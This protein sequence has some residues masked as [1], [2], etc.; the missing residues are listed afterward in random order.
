MRSPFLSFVV[1]VAVLATS[2]ASAQSHTVAAASA[3]AIRSDASA[4]QA[5][6]VPPSDPQRIRL[7]PIGT[8]RSNT[9]A[10]GGAE[11]V[12]HDPA[13]QRL[14]IVNGSSKSIDIVSVANPAAPTL[15]RSIAIAPTYGAAATSVDI[16]NGVLAVAVPAADETA[17]GKVV[18][19]NRE[20]TLINQVTVGVLPDMLTFTPDGGYVL[21]ANE[22]QPTAD[23]SVDPEGSV[24][25]VDV[26]NGATNA[27]VRAVRFTAFNEGQPRN[28]ELGDDVRVFG[29]G[30]SVAE[31]LEP[32]YIA[33]SPDGATA[34]VSLQEN[35]AIA[36]IDLAT[37]TVSSISVLGFKDYGAAGNGIDASDRDGGINIQNWPVKGMYQPDAI[38][39]YA[40]GGET[41]V[42][43][44]NEGDA[45][46]YDGFSEQVRVGS[47]D[48][49]LDPSSFPNAA[50]LQG[51]AQLGRLR[52]TNTLGRNGDDDYEE[53]YAFGGRSFSILNDE[54]EVI[55][56]SG[57]DIEQRTAQLYP[58][59]FNSDNEENSSFDNRSD[60]KGPEPE[61][62]A[63]GR[64]GGRT[65]A[66]I[67][68]ER[69]GGVMVY[70][71]TTP[72]SPTFVQ[73]INNRDFAGD[74][75]AGTAGDLGPEGLIFVPADDSP[76]SQPLVVV[77]NEISGSTTLYAV[78][79]ADSDGAGTLSLLHNNDGESSLLPIPN[80]VETVTGTVQLDTAGVAAFKT[81]TDRNIAQAEAA[82]NAVVNVY[83]GDAFLASATLACSLPPQPATTPIYDAVA[84][85]QID[86]DAHIIGN[87]EFDYSPDFLER[88][89]RA[90]EEGGELEEPFLSANLD[91]SGE[92]GFADL[93]DPD[94]L[95]E[96][97]VEDNRPLARSMVLTDTTTSQRF[98][99]VGATTP[100]LPTISSPRNVE[101]TPTITETAEAVQTEIDRLY[102]DLGVRKIILVSHLQ[103]VNNDR[104]LIPRL[105][106]V[107]LAVAGGGDELLASTSVPTT[108]QLLPGEAAPIA[109]SYPLEVGDADGRTVYVVTTA[110]NYKYLGR[111][112]VEFDA[113]GEVSDIVEATS[114]PRRVIPESATAT[115]LGLT[116]AVPPDPG[117]VSTVIEP[118][119]ECLA[120]FANTVVATSEVNLDVSRNGV[121]STESNGGNLI[122]D[123]F[124]A[125]YERYAEVNDL[126]STDEAKVIAVQNGGGIR[127]NAGDSLP[128]GGAPGPIT[129]LD[130]LN[131][132]PFDNF[133]SVVRNVT[134]ADLK[135]I[136]E[137]SAES[138]PGQGGQF[139][140]VAGIKV[141]Y[142]VG[143][144]VGSRVVSLV[145]DDGTPI[146]QNGEVVAGAPVVNVVTNSF[147]ANGGDNYP[148]FASYTDKPRLF[149]DEGIAISYEQTLVEYLQELGVVRAS[150]V[151]YRPGGD[152]RILIFNVLLRLPLVFK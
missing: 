148:T 80:T 63:V 113:E 57:D 33:V 120:E 21:T 29:P 79:A 114:Y 7:Q 124:L 145:L 150:D 83:A 14:Y 31:D 4:L 66:F 151:R 81:V 24:S 76:N 42:V 28:G 60:D 100:T 2:L 55:F 64:L 9:F 15:I 8:Y 121:R 109:G 118:V 103:D 62:L 91:F 45:R 53:L 87:H 49:V 133:M 92:P 75:A 44:A 54:G 10:E 78:E 107:D 82:G 144:P 127:Q 147:T 13:T 138:L 12:T 25:I 98:G 136:F 36:I 125:A 105:S 129:R 117:I 152:D 27:S 102:D 94:G 86:Y 19:F 65:Y 104:E 85:R 112:D 142:K 67:G 47:D 72:I 111:L 149:D 23:Y 139:L 89:I 41:Y 35:N 95:I 137:R 56:D 6:L 11:I 70:D 96:G 122:A 84:Q 69:I 126:P 90:F 34:Y 3:Q 58:D 52:I 115:T 140:Q 71:V 132:L 30:A 108:T 51:D 18:F 134:P 77:A 16:F 39:A 97:E 17:P 38:Q 5:A 101:V 61:G 74:P 135:T 128:Q 143:N 106:R 146:V 32:E 1:L 37:A 131:V 130:T 116:N 119:Q 46:D 22:G 43:T 50:A 59:D 141:V 93:I 68:L 40:S 48:V 20:G 73:Y 99:I 110:G 88:F 26:R 123:G